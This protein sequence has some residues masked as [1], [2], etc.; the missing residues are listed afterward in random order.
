MNDVVEQHVGEIERSLST[1]A[2][3]L[4][5]V[6]NQR[7]AE[8]G[9]MVTTHVED[10]QDAS[11]QSLTDIDMEVDRHV[12]RLN[13]TEHPRLAVR[14]ATIAMVIAVFALGVAAAALLT[15]G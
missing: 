2:S 3:E 13:L 10:I 8:F 7:F 6:A 9:R 11:T 4:N 15:A 5:E 12:G 14:V 1:S